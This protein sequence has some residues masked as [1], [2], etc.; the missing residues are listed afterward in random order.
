MKLENSS[1][2]F[3]CLAIGQPFPNVTWFFNN[4]L[5]VADNTKYI[6]G[7]TGTTFGALTIEDIKFADRGRY[8][9]K[10]SNLHGDIETSATLIVQGKLSACSFKCCNNKHF[11][12]I[13]CKYLIYF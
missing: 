9:C 1:V 4:Q 2:T 13:T 3:F 12:I 5:I 8:T 11:I 10:Y 7:N 6:I